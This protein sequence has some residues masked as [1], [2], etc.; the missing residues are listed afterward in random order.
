MAPPIR[1][2]ALIVDDD[3][4]VLDGLK[5]A[6]RGEPYDISTARDVPEA[7][8]SLHRDRPQV[9]VS[10]HH[11]PSG[12]GTDLLINA[13]ALLTDSC[14]IL[15]TGSPTLDM[16][17]DAINQGAITRLFLKPFQ[18]AQMAAAIREALEKIEM[19]HLS[20]RMLAQAKLYRS[21]IDR[22]HT[23]APHLVGE[24]GPNQRPGTGAIQAGDY[25]PH[26]YGAILRQLRSQV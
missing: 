15:M 18:I 9:I 20:L 8:V 11:L 19:A 13:K 24:S 14:R 21:V 12:L 5:T 7:T 17:V 4:S 3:A 16:A 23:S 10:D 25:Q 26:D 1:Y 22:I 2:R 6:L